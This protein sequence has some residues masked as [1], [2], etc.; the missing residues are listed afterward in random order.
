M[1]NSKYQTMIMIGITL[2]FL[3]GVMIYTSLSAPKEY[4]QSTTVNDQ[5]QTAIQQTSQTLKNDISTTQQHSSNTVVEVN[6]TTAFSGVLNLNTCT[7]E[8]LAN[9]DG[10]GEKRAFL[11]VAYRD[12]L[13]SYTSVEQIKDISGIGDGVYDQISPYLTV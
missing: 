9:I 12:K 7:E 11:I 2:V 1:N 6:D 10:V 13:G 4:V 8:D 5:T 3:A